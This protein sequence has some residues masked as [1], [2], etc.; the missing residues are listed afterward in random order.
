VV[1]IYKKRKF[2]K[3]AYSNHTNNF[4]TTAR[5]NN[6]INPKRKKQENER[7]TNANSASDDAH[8]HCAL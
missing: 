6:T 1:Y 2:S 5:A 3:Q 7:E 8:N 4:E